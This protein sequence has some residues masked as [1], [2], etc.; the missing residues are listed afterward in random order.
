MNKTN[1]TFSLLEKIER[2]NKD[3]SLFDGCKKILVGLSGGADSTCLL[4]SMNLLRE[5]YGF[6][7]FAVHVNHMIRSHEAERDEAF[8]KN[9]CEKLGVSFLCERVNVPTL[10]EKSGQSL[11]LCARNERYKVFAKVC[12][13]HGITHIATAHNCCDNAETM[14]FNLVR[15]SGTKGLCG[16]PAKRDDNDGLLIV[17]PLIYVLRDEIEEFLSEHNQDFVTDSTNNDVDYTR[18]YIRHEILPRLRNINPALDTSFIKTASLV[19]ND[20]DYLDC[21][22]GKSVSNNLCE[23]SMLDVSILSRVVRIMY[24]DVSSE[25]PEMVHINALCKKIYEYKENENVKCRISFPDGFCASIFRGKL[26]FVKDVKKTEA[27]DFEKSLCEGGHFFENSPYA[28]YISF[29]QNRDNPQTLSNK[30]NI[31]KKYTTDYLYFDTIPSVIYARNKRNGDKIHSGKMHKSVKRLLLASD[32]DQNSKNLV[33]IITDGEKIL[34][35]P[36]VSVCDDCKMSENGK[37]CVAVSLY[38]KDIKE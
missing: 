25:M 14:L 26:S 6:E 35:V 19:K 29:Y 33:P 28:L 3:F 27:G 11:E 34:A 22:A 9:L 24:S 7:I 8:A 21:I 23:L 32:L 13:E 37:E 31:Y 5:K 12:R 17:R 10:C 30:E 36:G 15:G 20:S 2:A 16:I 38:I 4:L 18:N 1:I